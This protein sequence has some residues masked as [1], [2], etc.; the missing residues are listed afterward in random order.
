MRPRFNHPSRSQLVL[1]DTRIERADR[2]TLNGMWTFDEP[3]FGRQMHQADNTSIRA[4][5]AK[6]QI[7]TI[8]IL[9]DIVVAK[10]YHEYVSIA[11]RI[12][13]NRRN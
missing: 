10:R 13:V 8:G 3:P 11:W 4:R 7:K 5:T 6:P 9:S 12:G 1:R 2:F